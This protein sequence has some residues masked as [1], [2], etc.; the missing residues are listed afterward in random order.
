MGR[1][2]WMLF[3]VQG[4]SLVELHTQMGARYRW[5]K[6]LCGKKILAEKHASELN[7]WKHGAIRRPE[8]I[9]SGSNTVPHEAQHT[10]PMCHM[11]HRPELEGAWHGTF[12]HVLFAIDG[13][14]AKSGSQKAHHHFDRPLLPILAIQCQIIHALGAIRLRLSQTAHCRLYPFSS[15]M[16]NDVGR[17]A[18]RTPELDVF[19]DNTD[20]TRHSQSFQCSLLPSCGE[21][22]VAA[23]QSMPLAR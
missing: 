20:N 23:C 22:E 7:P 2:T 1:R 13:Y 4:F 8:R 14:Q 18:R 10:L 12:V 11:R 15:E 3:D 6:P 17:P 19:Y 21:E 9:H 16:E 5:C